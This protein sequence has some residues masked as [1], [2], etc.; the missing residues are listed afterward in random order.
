[1]KNVLLF[2]LESDGYWNS[3]E[4]LLVANNE[5]DLEEHLE[6][7]YNF[8]LVTVKGEQVEIIER[9]GFEKKIGQITWIKFV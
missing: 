9:E 1:M 4:I 7:E 6:H 5:K 3:K 2:R 8:H